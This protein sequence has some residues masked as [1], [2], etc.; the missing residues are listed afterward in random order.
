MAG[1]CCKHYISNSLENTKEKD[2]EQHDRSH[3]DTTV[4]QQDLLD[5]YMPAF[6][7]CVE[8]AKVTGLMC[9]YNSVNG[10]PMCANSHLLKDI[11][12]GEWGFEGYVTSDCD[13]DENVYSTHHY[14]NHTPDQVVADVLHAGTD[15]DC[16]Q[17]VT[18]H[19]PF[20]L[21]NKTITEAD[22]DERLRAQF[23]V[24]F[25]LGHFDPVGPLQTLSDKTEVCTKET[26]AL[27]FDGV[28]QSSALL[29]NRNKTLPL[30]VG[31]RVAVIGPNANLSKMDAGYYGPHFVCGM[32]FWTLVDAVGLHASSVVS[33]LGIECIGNPCTSVDSPDT[34]QIPAAVALARTVDEV[35]LAVGT[36]NSMAAE[37]RDAVNLTFSDAQLLLVT[38]LTIGLAPIL[39]G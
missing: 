30:A 18:A 1:A 25:R 29:K 20:A 5:S 17:F 7:S 36:D 14:K 15:V 4:T 39:W 11:A 10:V 26:K 37:G 32:K 34:T 27:S 23:T 13:A 3:V 35:V 21:G 6:Q 22:I 9:G 33:A 24:R 2:G 19:A 31:K 16:G 8:K 12:R 28:A 38:G